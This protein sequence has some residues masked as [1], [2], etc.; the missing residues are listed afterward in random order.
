[1]FYKVNVS[2]VVAFLFIQVN[3]PEMINC[4][5]LIFLEFPL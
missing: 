1:M 3:F 5:P 2:K 4:I